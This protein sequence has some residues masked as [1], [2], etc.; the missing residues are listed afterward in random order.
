MFGIKKKLAEGNE[1]FRR[2]IEEFQHRGLF[3]EGKISILRRTT[4]FEKSRNDST[5]CDVVEFRC[6]KGAAIYCLV[7][8]HLED[9]K[10]EVSLLGNIG[11]AARLGGGRSW[12]LDEYLKSYDDIGHFYAA[13]NKGMF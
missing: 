9:G 6:G 1:P 8:A 3:Q 7:I 10:T 11:F 12:Y 4:G 13:E 5:K 2:Y